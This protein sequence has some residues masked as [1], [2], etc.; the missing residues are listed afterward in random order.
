MEVPV[1]EVKKREAVGSRAS[2]RLREAGEV[3]VVLYGL[4]R[5]TIALCIERDHVDS[6]VRHN[7]H[8][9]DLS[10][11][12]EQQQALVSDVHWDAMGDAVLHVDFLRIRRDEKVTVTIPL[13]FEGTP[14]GVVEGG[15]INQ[16]LNDLEVEC[17]PSNIPEK[18]VVDV[19]GL[20]IGEH[21]NVS[22]L[23]IPQGVE[24]LAEPETTVVTVI[25]HEPVLEEEEAAEAE[26]A[27]EEPEILSQKKD[28]EEGEDTEEEPS[29]Q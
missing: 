2:R 28:E 19:S 17:L 6:I 27:S 26:E 3:P 9:V 11:D 12:G 4:K 16:V 1:I 20:A 29:A 15:V 10:L 8:I 18:I 13:E 24:A 7:T 14:K 5:P 22:D 23:A 21:L 25:F